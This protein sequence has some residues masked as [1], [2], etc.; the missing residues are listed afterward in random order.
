MRAA[1]LR[2]G[3]LQVSVRQESG[4]RTADGRSDEAGFGPLVTV[5]GSFGPP[6]VAPALVRTSPECADLR[7]GAVLDEPG[8][9]PGR[10]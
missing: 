2:A 7:V 3:V 8:S 5:G 1:R 4:L 9:A 6:V 10:L